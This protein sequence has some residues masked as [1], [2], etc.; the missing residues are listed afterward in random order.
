MTEG[1]GIDEARWREDRIRR[2]SDD[3]DERD[4]G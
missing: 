1:A 4:S 3:E 2:R